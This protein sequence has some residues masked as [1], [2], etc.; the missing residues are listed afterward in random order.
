MSG[1][2]RLDMEPITVAIADEDEGRLAKFESSLQ[3]AKDIKVLTNIPTTALDKTEDRRAKPRTNITHIENAVARVRRL[4][5]RVL[6]ANLKQCTDSDC[7]MLLSLR[8]ECPETLVVLLADES[9]KEDESTQEEDLVM[10]AL[11]IGA[12]GYLSPEADAHYVSKAVHVIDRGEAWVS[13]KMFGKIMDQWCN[14]N[15]MGARLD[16]SC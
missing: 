7:S 13:R 5:P 6:L 9:K 2:E 12:R 16:S 15:S 14:V 3:D 4:K 8:H 1:I 10:R 11:A